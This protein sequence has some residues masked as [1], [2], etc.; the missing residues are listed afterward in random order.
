M[1]D[2]NAILTEF[3]TLL[4]LPPMPRSSY[5]AW[6]LADWSA[7]KSGIRELYTKPIDPDATA[8]TIW[9]KLS[10]CI[11]E[12]IKDHVPIKAIS[13]K[14][15]HR[16]PLPRKVIRLIRK[17][18]RAV[19]NARRH[20][21]S[22]ALAKAK[23]LE[24]DVVKAC[25][26]SNRDHLLDISN[27]I[28]TAP[29]RFW[30]YIKSQRVDRTNI[31]DMRDPDGTLFSDPCLKANLFNEY[32]KSV[33]TAEPMGPLPAFSPRCPSVMNKITVSVPGVIKQLK[34]LDA[35]KSQ[36]NDEIPPCFLKECAAELAPMLTLLFQKSLD[37]GE[38]PD[39]WLDALV[40]PIH[41]K[42]EKDIPSN[43]RPISLTSVT[44]KVLEH[45]V[46]SNIYSHLDRHMLLSPYQ[47]GFR[48]KHSTVGQLISV[49]HD[50]AKSFEQKIPIDSIFLD[51]A[52]AFD[53]VPHQRLLHKISSYGIQGQTLQ[54]ISNFL[55]KRR[56]CV[57]VSGTK[58]NWLPVTSGVPQGTVMG[59]LLFLI[60]VN[61]ITD[62]TRSSLRLFAD[63]T[64]LYRPINNEADTQILQSDLNRLSEW[65]D[66]WLLKINIDK[67]VHLRVTSC[68]RH[69]EN[70][71][72]Y[73]LNGN[74]L[75]QQDSTKYLGVTISSNLKWTKHWN[76]TCNKAN[77][78]LGLLRRNLNGASKQAKRIAY[79]SL[80]RSKLE[81]ATDV[82]DPHTKGSIKQIEMV[83]RRGL[84][85]ISADYRR[86]SSVRE[87]RGSIGIDLLE[88]RRKFNRLKTLQNIYTGELE[89]P[90]APRFRYG[91]SIQPCVSKRTP[92]NTFFY[93]SLTDTYALSNGDPLKQSIKNT[94]LGPYA[95]PIKF[96]YG[97]PP[98]S[99]AVTCRIPFLMMYPQP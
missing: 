99:A 81:Y 87:M 15:H 19:R 48:K 75:P 11:H 72:S 43:Y 71:P 93:R 41:K 64:M 91:F 92:R 35:G 33:F 73:L 76:E 84:R 85:F 18:R 10:N 46:Y 38:L 30:S 21:S 51:F 9:T 40:N 59:P 31:P 7:I 57:V 65:I 86:S 53:K 3:Q 5:K 69:S 2:H 29:K 66:K 96:L 42:G 20:N 36:G 68:K 39:D 74:I 90:N 58:S 67:C 37:T 28:S 23:Q 82:T 98:S 47:H 61:D 95:T 26:F 94:L 44:C 13:P 1:S 97:G 79:Q 63:D 34:S 27:S 83:Q 8:N 6:H 80:V 77:S 89:V 60:Y 16:L 49:A 56:Q 22:S 14:G 17:K 24:K 55:T 12:L 52:K 88:T 70:S 25:K 45:I 62:V 32:F 78:M 50:W 4:A 54:W